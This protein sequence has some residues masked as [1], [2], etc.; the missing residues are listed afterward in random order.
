MIDIIDKLR[1]FGEANEYHVIFGSDE[2][3]NADRHGYKNGEIVMAIEFTEEVLNF[4]NT[5]ILAD[6]GSTYNYDILFGRKFEDYEEHT[7]SSLDETMSQK[8]DRRLQYLRVLG[9]SK[10]KEFACANNIG[11]QSIRINYVI[12]AFND[13]IDFVLFDTTFI[14]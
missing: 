3:K 6:S 11:L 9:L 5:N 10:L 7:Y 1:K 8:Q 13:N 2:Y 4:P 14:V 12:N